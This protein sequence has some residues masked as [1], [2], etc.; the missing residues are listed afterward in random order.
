[1]RIGT[2]APAAWSS[3]RAAPV[4]EAGSWADRASGKF[5]PE[6][7]TTVRVASAGK[8]RAISA[9]VAKRSLPEI[10]WTSV[11][12]GRTGDWGVGWASGPVGD[13][14]AT[15]APP[16]TSV[17]A[18]PAATRARRLEDGRGDMAILLLTGDERLSV[19]P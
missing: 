10:R 7:I 1:S 19:E 18:A 17:S 2:G 15:W 6:A 9:A 5:T 12:S 16:A 8:D 4:T 14:D 13:E 11:G 3:P